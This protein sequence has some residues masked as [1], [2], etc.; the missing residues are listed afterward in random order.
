MTGQGIDLLILNSN[1]MYHYQMR[2][3]GGGHGPKK[4]M[5]TGLEF[6]DRTA[7]ACARGRR[8]ELVKRQPGNLYRFVVFAGQAEPELTNRFQSAFN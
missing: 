8:L 2:R 5:M 3:C 1:C 4:R 7:A 6:S